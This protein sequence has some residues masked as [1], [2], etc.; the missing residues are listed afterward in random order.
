MRTAT[1]I[2]DEMIRRVPMIESAVGIAL[3][4]M[5]SRMVANTTY[6]DHRYR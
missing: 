3:K 5:R 1:Y 6:M 2:A 4:N